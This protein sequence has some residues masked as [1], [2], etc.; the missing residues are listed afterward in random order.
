MIVNFQPPATPLEHSFP[1]HFP[2][3]PGA[4]PSISGEPDIPLSPRKAAG[5]AGAADSFAAALG[6]ALDAAAGLIDRAGSAERAFASGRG[7]L[8]EMVVSRAQADVTLALAA[9]AASRTTQALSTILG[10][11][12]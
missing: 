8:Q 11:Q 4:P 9:A 7:G 12:I 3:D 5:D 6:R 10:M 2:G 1:P